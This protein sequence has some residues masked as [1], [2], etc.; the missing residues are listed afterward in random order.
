M[1]LTKKYIK[2]KKRNTV[3]V[4]IPIDEYKKLEEIMENYGLAKL[5]DEVKDDD[6]LLINEAKSYYASLKKNVY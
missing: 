3:A 1:I 5:I 2:D 4:Q 6:H